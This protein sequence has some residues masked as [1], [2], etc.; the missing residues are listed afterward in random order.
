MIFNLNIEQKFIQCSIGFIH[1]CIAKETQ[2][3]STR[4]SVDG[5]IFPKYIKVSKEPELTFSSTAS[6][7]FLQ[8]NSQMAMMAAKAIPAMSIM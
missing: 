6:F 7:L 4:N 3:Y 2:F 5:I 8:V 1:R